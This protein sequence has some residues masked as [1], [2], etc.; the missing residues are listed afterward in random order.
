MSEHN[1]L[2]E[3]ITD[4]EAFDI[5]GRYLKYIVKGDFFDYNQV[6]EHLQKNGAVLPTEAED[7]EAMLYEWF[8][9]IQ[10]IE[11]E[12]GEPIKLIQHNVDGTWMFALATVVS[13]KP[14][15]V[16][17]VIEVKPLV[18]PAPIAP[19]VPEPTLEPKP[20]PEPTPSYEAAATEP[21]LDDKQIQ[22]AQTI[23]RIFANDD[24]LARR[25]PKQ[26]AQEVLPEDDTK[27][28]VWTQYI[29]TICRNLASLNLLEQ[30][31]MTRN[32]HTL[33]FSMASRGIRELLKSDEGREYIQLHLE[34]GEPFSSDEK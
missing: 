31:D 16:E 21:V 33:R 22:A 4:D 20:T 13:Q 30:V 25:T 23:L 11:Q 15:E 2:P 27:L 9:E 28:P 1:E 18:K 29:R 6:V 26:L 12:Q 24:L 34:L 5:T 17:P 19:P 3:V 7:R 32:K 14:V 8:D 10:A